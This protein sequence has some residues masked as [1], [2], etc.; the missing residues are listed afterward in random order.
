MIKEF[1][2]SINNRYKLLTCIFIFSILIKS[3]IF[4][5]SGPR[6]VSF[7]LCVKRFIES[8]IRQR[9]ENGKKS[10]VLMWQFTNKFEW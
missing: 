1:G 2:E 9:I 10:A 5:L 4:Q 3:F 8:L 7:T 6:P